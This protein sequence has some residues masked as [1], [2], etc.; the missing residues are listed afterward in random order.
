MA[1]IFKGKG[2]HQKKRHKDGEEPIPVMP[3][4]KKNTFTS[5]KEKTKDINNDYRFDKNKT[6]LVVGGKVK[7]IS[8]KS[9]YLLDML[10]IEEEN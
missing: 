1:I 4:P 3:S 7:E 8:S 9:K 5:T 10:I 6:Y 2:R